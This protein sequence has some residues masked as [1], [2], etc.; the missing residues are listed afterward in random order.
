MEQELVLLKRFEKDNEWFHKNTEKL[1]GEGFVGKFV[2]IKDSR[3]IASDKNVD[4]LIREIEKKGEN[5]AFIVI[6][7]VYPQGYTLIL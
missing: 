5:P 2:A 6:E 7:F 4:V 3:L 1:Q